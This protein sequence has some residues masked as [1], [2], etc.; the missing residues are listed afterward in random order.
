MRCWG[1]APVWMRGRLTSARS[2]AAIA[3]KEYRAVTVRLFQRRPTAKVSLGGDA[4]AAGDSP[5]RPRRGGA[6]T[7]LQR[8]R[9]ARPD[10][11]V[12]PAGRA[13]AAVTRAGRGAPPLVVGRRAPA[14]GPGRPAGARGPRRR[15]PG[16][17]LRQP[18]PG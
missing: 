9:V 11:P 4:H 5:E 16:H 6:Q 1:L 8:L 12:D 15:A 7:A 2:V 18:R 10:A 3:D 14:R 17:R 13:D